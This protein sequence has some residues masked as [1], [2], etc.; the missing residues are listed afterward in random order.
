MKKG[1]E[2]NVGTTISRPHFEEITEDKNGIT[3]IALIITIIIM[4]ILVGVTVNV[5]LNGGLFETAKQAASGMNKAQIEEKAEMTKVV[6][7]ADEQT[8]AGVT[9]NIPTYRDRLLEEF[10]AK[11]TDR[12]NIIE[13]NDKYAIII[14]NSE[15]D[16]E[17]VEKTNIPAKYLL[18]SLECETSNIE[19]NEKIYGKNVAINITRLMDETEYEEL[20]KEQNSQIQVPEETKKQVFLQYFNEAFL[21]GE[22]FSSVDEVVIYD[23]NEYYGENYTT[24]EECLENES[25]QEEMGK[26]KGQLYYAICV[27]YMY[28]KDSVEDVG[29]NE[30]TEQELIDFGYHFFTY[31]KEFYEYTG[32]SGELE[33]YVAID[34]E[35][36]ETP[37]GEAFF[38][39]NIKEKTVNYSIE[40]NGTYEFIL[41]TKNGE[42]MAREVVRVNDI[43]TD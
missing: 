27:Y 8:D 40:E 11:E 34:G 20:R 42:E 15:L 19:E 12:Y 25:V 14:K 17:V 9:A 29:A 24:I 43:V 1:N 30:L 38:N 22:P 39:V 35:E 36:Q 10:D 37:I 33:L 2:K 41:K 18:I 13:V 26:T 32:I 6:L 31:Q 28:E 23:I 3:L 5:A 7:M 16:I 21:P 4:L